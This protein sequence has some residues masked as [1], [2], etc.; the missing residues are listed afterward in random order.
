MSFSNDNF[1]DD[2]VNLSYNTVVSMIIH[3]H[4]ISGVSTQILHATLRR[5]SLS[6]KFTPHGTVCRCVEG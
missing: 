5:L 2:I 4:N 1:Y 6:T 3:I